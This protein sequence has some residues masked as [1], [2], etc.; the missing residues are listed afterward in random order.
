MSSQ[1]DIAIE[2]IEEKIAELEKVR[3]TLVEM[4]DPPDSLRRRLL[5]AKRT[6]NPAVD[7]PAVESRPPEMRVT[8][9]FG[10]GNG[11]GHGHDIGKSTR[12]DEV[13]QF[14]RERGGSA[15]RSVIIAGTGIPKGTVAY[16]LNDKTRF[17]GRHGLWRNVEHNKD[18]A[19]ASAE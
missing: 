14:I 19:G 10:S 4:F 11:H 3:D 12:K 16:V 15:K 2:Q 7:I 13:A 6:P 18:S 5:A 8:N 17:V 1:I 9:L